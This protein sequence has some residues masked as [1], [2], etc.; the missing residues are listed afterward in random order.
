[1]AGVLV[2]VP[3]K[4]PLLGRLEISGGRSALGGPL[5]ADGG[6]AAGLRAG[7]GA[8]TPLGPVRFD[9]GLGLHGRE[10]L[11]VRIGRWF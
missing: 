9:Y 11:F 3:L 8:E 4:G 2:A 5:L 7:L 1:M 10:A 6:W